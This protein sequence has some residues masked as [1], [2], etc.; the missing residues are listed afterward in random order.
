MQRH[1]LPPQ[2][3]AC[4]KEITS[5]QRRKVSIRRKVRRKRGLNWGRLRKMLTYRLGQG[6][7]IQRRVR[8]TAARVMH[9]V[10]PAPII[11]WLKFSRKYEMRWDWNSVHR[12]HLPPQAAINPTNKW[13]RTWSGNFGCLTESLTIAM[14]MRNFCSPNKRCYKEALSQTLIFICSFELVGISIPMWQLS[15]KHFLNPLTSK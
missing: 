13:Y 12:H 4:R 3:P 11:T 8:L 7:V 1:A 5:S 9:S 14:S 2:R 15:M 6:H 10:R